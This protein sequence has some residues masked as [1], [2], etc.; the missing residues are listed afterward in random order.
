[1]NADQRQ[2]ASLIAV[3]GPVEPGQAGITDA[4]NHVWIAPVVDA[5]SAGPVLDDERA[6]TSELIAYREAGGST[7]IDCQ[8]GGCGRDGRVLKRLA[9]ASGVTIVACTGFHLRRYY[10]V[11]HPFFDLSAEAACQHFVSEITGYLTETDAADPVCAGF[12]KIACEET[13]Q[14]SPLN[15]IEGAVAASHETGTAIEVH[16]EKGADA[17]RIVQ[18]MADFGLPASRLVLCHVDKRPDFA[19][20]RAMARHGVMLEYDTFYRGKYEPDANVWPLLTRMVEAGLASQV[21]IATDMAE[22]AM[23]RSMGG[24]P[25]LTA[26][27]TQIMPR[28]RAIGCDDLT[29]GQLVGANITGRLARLVDVK[30]DKTP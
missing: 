2:S 13:L 23:W 15:L 4:H 21:T 20:H 7:I 8:P 1:M 11:D 27:I 16:T 30:S 17:E 19:F 25:G 10:P 18:A 26:L 12:I 6:I 9:Q 24:G 28:L 14:Q 29:I 22:A 5:A 3:T